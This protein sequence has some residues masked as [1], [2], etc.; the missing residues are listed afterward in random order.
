[1][2]A[3]EIPLSVSRGSVATQRNSV[4]YKKMSD[5]DGEITAGVCVI[6]GS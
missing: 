1:M 3:G 6:G 5:V 2:M 4:S